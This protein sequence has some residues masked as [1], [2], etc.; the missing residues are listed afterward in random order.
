MKYVTLFIHL[1]PEPLIVRLVEQIPKTVTQLTKE[2]DR[3]RFRMPGK[4]SAV[5][6]I[7]TFETYGLSGSVG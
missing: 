6:N 3:G 1:G 4:C 5:L 7:W 2:S